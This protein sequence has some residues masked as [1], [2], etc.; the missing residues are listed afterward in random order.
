MHIRYGSVALRLLSVASI[1]AL[2]GI[3]VVGMQPIIETHARA[4]AV[5]ETGLLGFLTQATRAVNSRHIDEITPLVGEGAVRT[6]GWV[7]DARETWQGVS[8]ALPSATANSGAPAA[9]GEM[10]AVFHAWH[11]CQSDGDHVHRL[12]HSAQG[13]RLGPEI[14]ET[15]TLGF[16][17]RDHDLNVTFDLPGKNVTVT[18]TIQVERTAEQVP[19]FGLLRIS[20]DFQIQSITHADVADKTPVSFHQAGGI[21]AFT[22]PTGRKFALTLH[23]T[24]HLDNRESDYIRTDEAVLCSYWYPHIG[25]L[26]ARTSVTV[27]TPPEWKAIAQGEVVREAQTPDGGSTVTFRN[28]VANCFY[29]L[30]IGRYTITSRKVKERTLSVYQLRANPALA[31]T[32]LD[33]LSATMDYYEHNFAPFPYTR[34]AV[35]ETQGAFAGA[36]EAYSFATFGPNT[37]PELIAHEFAHSW[38]G[39]MIPCTYTHS[40][41]DEAFAEY[42]DDLFTR[43]HPPANQNTSPVPPTAPRIFAE[44]RRNAEAYASVAVAQAYDTEDD[45]HIA[46]G[47]EKGHQVLKM[48]EMQLGQPMMLRC[49]RRFFADHPK[50]EAADWREF[51]AAVQRETGTDYRWFFAEW[52]ERSG[53]P[54]LALAHTAYHK[55]PKGYL[56]ETDV[57]QEKNPYRLEMP[58]VLEITGGQPLQV[59]KEIDGATTHLTF[60]V[61]SVPTRMR[62]DPKGEVLFAPPASSTPFADPTLFTFKP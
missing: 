33:R 12:L 14:P 20:H 25:R 51:E 15:E 32:C 1:A 57:V 6:F 39:G 10:L 19:P 54:T 4:Q 9:P 53:V 58:I 52:L 48:L 34:Y 46:A 62:L 7:P 37:L 16:R 49:M 18:D 45:H 21:I 50:G 47:Y 28:E 44:R 38:W 56:V 40:M 43:S 2:V 30:D 22:P 26:P 42:S 61:T 8:L 35:V 55:D 59:T 27:T 3:G 5:V 60:H 11:S 23:Y 17:V 29:T 41:W 36:L 31:Q 24:G 13:W